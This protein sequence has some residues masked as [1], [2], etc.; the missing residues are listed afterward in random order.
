M[1][2]DQIEESQTMIPDGKRV[3]QTCVM[4]P[5][6]PGNL[7]ILI[8]VTLLKYKKGLVF[9]IYKECLFLIVYISYNSHR[10]KWPTE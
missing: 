10:D 7:W 2:R 8:G 9:P 4:F 5:H 6:R 1:L 3:T